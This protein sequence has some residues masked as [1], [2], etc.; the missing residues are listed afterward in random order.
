MLEYNLKGTISNLL[1]K[2]MK[3]FMLRKNV[4]EAGLASSSYQ[5]IDDTVPCHGKTQS[6]HVVCNPYYTAY[7]T[8]PGKDRL[9]VLD[10]L[11]QGA[12][13]SICSTPKPWT[14][15]M[16]A[17][18]RSHTLHIGGMALGGGDGRRDLSARVRQAY[19]DL[20]QT[21]SQRVLSA[22][23]VAAYHANAAFRSCK[24]WSVMMRRSSNG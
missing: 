8:K 7:F 18:F 12:N 9:S 16:D 24:H 6:C 19:P 3:V 1:V 17:I 4:Y 21:A 10:V 13:G 20:E 5:H 11:R 23:A 15:W 22:A 2:G 14:T